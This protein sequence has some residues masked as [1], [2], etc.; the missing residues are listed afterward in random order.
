VEVQ[1]Q[2]FS[3]LEVIRRR[4]PWFQ[5]PDIKAQFWILGCTFTLEPS[6]GDQLIDSVNSLLAL[7]G[8]EKFEAAL[9]EAQNLLKQPLAPLDAATCLYTIGCARKELGDVAGALPFLLESHATFPTT[10]PLLIGHVQDE[11]ARIQFNLKFYASAV[12]FTEMA[13]ANF[14]LGGNAEMKASCEAL[15]EEILWHA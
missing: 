15:R 11:V 10:E 9:S 14:E 3:F 6:G 4:A 8:E 7:M 13:I 1:T 5:A 2:G 12:F